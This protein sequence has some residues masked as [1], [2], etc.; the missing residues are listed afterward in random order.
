MD[1]GRKLLFAFTLLNLLVLESLAIPG[2]WSYA[3]PDDENVQKAA[4]LAVNEYEK[5]TD[6]MFTS[7]LV[8]ITKAETQVVAG[9]NYR[10][11]VEI[12][13]TNCRKN[14]IR[15]PDSS[16]QTQ[17]R[18]SCTFVVWEQSW[19]DHIEVTDTKC[20]SIKS[21]D[22]Q[23]EVLPPDVSSET[24][25]EIDEAAAFAV[26]HLQS[27]SNGR[28]TMKLKHVVDATRMTDGGVL[29][30][31]KIECLMSSCKSSGRLDDCTDGVRDENV[32]CDVDVLNQQPKDPQ[33]VVKK[34]NCAPGSASKGHTRQKSI[35]VI[36]HLEAFEDFK[37]R[38]GVQYKNM[39]E[40]S[41]RFNVFEDNLETI[42]FLQEHELGTATY[43][44]T[45]FADLTPDEFRKRHLT[46]AWDQSEDRRLVPAKIPKVT[47]PTD[48]DWRH[49]NAVTS[50]KNQGSC[51]SCWAFSVTGNIEG[52]WAIQK[53]KLVPLSEQELV[54]CDKLDSGCNGGLPSY[55]YTEIQRLGGLET[56]T[57]YPYKGRDE[58]CELKTQ[59]IRVYI[60]GSLNISKDE[61]EM[62]AWLYK[63]GP[64]SIGIN[65]FAMQFYFGGVSHPWKIFCSPDSLDH[66]VLIVGYGIEKSI[67]FGDTPYWLVKNSWGTWWGEKGYYLV[68]RGDGT[69]GLNNMVS[70]AIIK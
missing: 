51:G 46:P 44:V 65:A 9:I 39:L 29:Y 32:T 12:G 4:R 3:D 61:N 35:K 34:Y 42:K 47:L 67:I 50:V 28:Y 62:A 52:Q 66:G 53:K 26:L 38:F 24:D 11:T 1:V 36:A 21:N 40:E 69:C 14:A 60:N 5:R 2:G 45:Q 59:D 30:H 63:N 25:S 20:G 23:N 16:C 54:D 57:D 58:S 43:G 8:K 33:Y 68:Y 15:D 56:E 6:S 55:A 41:Y 19:L 17:Q 70:S 64:M 31:L 10:V 48:Y 13:F 22:Y 37:K 49:Y 7:Q 27:L 18:Q